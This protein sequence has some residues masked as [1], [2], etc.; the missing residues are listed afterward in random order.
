M[1]RTSLEHS[2]TPTK[3]RALTA[4]GVAVATG[5]LG[6]AA[7]TA[8]EAQAASGKIFA[9]YS[10][11]TGALKISKSH[12]CKKGSK[13]ISWNASGPRGATGAAGVV[14]GY[15]KYYYSEKALPY[16]TDTVVETI[17]PTSAPGD[18][19]V[20]ANLDMYI[21]A[22]E[23]YGGCDIWRVNASGKNLESSTRFTFDSGFSNAR[24]VPIPGTGILALPAA[25]DKLELVCKVSGGT[26]T[27]S[28]EADG[29]D[30]DAVRVST[31]HISEAAKLSASSRP[32]NSFRSAKSLAAGSR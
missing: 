9:C 6:V 18:Y 8:A 15:D 13:L 29:W 22:D 27:T 1:K 24:V 23:G 19:L 31:A 12:K 21:P 2:R 4:T 28:G 25:G 20:N 17:S 3:V 30:F 5:A 11:K 14:A 26:A 32:Q 7:V 10:K 16:E